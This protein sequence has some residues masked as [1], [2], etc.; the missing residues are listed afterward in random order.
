MREVVIGMAHRGRLN[1]LVNVLGKKPQDLFD[2]FA[3]KH[4]ETWGTGDVKYHQGFSADFAT[5]GGDVHL[6][7]AFNPSHLEI[8]NP[9]VIG[10][11]R[12]RQD[13]LG[14]FDGSRVLPITIHGDSAIA[15][16]GVVAETFNMSLARGFCVGGTVRIVVNNQVGFTT[17][18]PR[19]TRSTMYCTDIAKMVQAPIFHVNA[20]DPEAV[21]FVTRIALDYRNEFKRDVVIDLVCYRRHGHNEADEPNATQPLMYQKIKKHPTPRKLYADVLIDK[22]ESDIEVAT[23]LVNEYRDALDKGEVV[24]KEW[25]PM[26]LHSVD[27]SPYLGHDWDVEWDNKFDS[28][29]LKELGQR[30]I[31]YP[32]SHKLQSRVNKLYN[33]RAAMISGEKPLDWGMAE[34]LA[35]ATLVDDGKRIRISGQDS[36]RGTFFHRH[37]VLH[38]Q[39]DASTYI[40]LANIHDKQ[41][42]FQVF[43][44]VLSEEAVLAFEYGYATAEPSGLTIWEAQFGD[45]ANGAQVV[46]DQFISSG[47]QKWARLCGLT[48][49]L[50][51]GYE[52]QVPEHSSARLERYLQLCAEQ[53]MQVVVPST[54]AQVYHMIRRQ[55]VRPMRRPLIVMSPKSL[56]RH[57]LCT[58]SLEDLS[59]GT[60]QPAIP[61]ID[62]LEP[63]KVKRVVFCSGKVYFDLLEQ[64]RNN[65]QDDVAIV[66]IE[67]LYPFPMEEVQAAIEQYTNVEDFVWC[68]EEPQNQG[69]WY[70]SQ[71]NF[72]A[73]IPAGADLKYAGRPASASPAVGYMS[74]HL[75][76]QKALVEDALNVNSKT[77]N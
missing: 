4:D 54:P 3:G 74:V 65:E 35:Y 1:M 7:L 41:G 47:E 5:P 31:Q 62:N 55:V 29:R 64:R 32:D 25:R 69:A 12:A 26:A 6:A 57:P 56:L 38:N 16:Q 63:S 50:P 20:D 24:V 33:D 67:Q 37:S 43:D 77:S 19:D 71:H 52:G 48:M 18:N 2:E 21:A 22:N 70:C 17:S 44:S 28:T 58:S 39:N 8:V 14:D 73:A 34:T 46:I 75:K 10:S 36:G 49:L 15:G 13:R 30:L 68:Q 61:E 51:H 23:Q 66:R 72:R 42:A 45:F 60:F 11:V 40:P 76:Q 59:E 27:W 53:N 9:V